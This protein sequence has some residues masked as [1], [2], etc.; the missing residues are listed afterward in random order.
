MDNNSKKD[1]NQIIEES[2]IEKI[3]GV[4]INEWGIGMEH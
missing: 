1:Y 2:D 3:G 4:D